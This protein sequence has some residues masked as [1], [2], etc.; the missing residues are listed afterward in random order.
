MLFDEVDRKGT[1]E[2][3]APVGEIYYGGE[4]QYE[5]VD[6]LGAGG[7]KTYFNANP[8]TYELK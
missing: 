3:L 4:Q 6:Y 5:F 1:S 7:W 8:I 2:T